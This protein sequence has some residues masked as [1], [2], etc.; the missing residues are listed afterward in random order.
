MN[1]ENLFLLQNLSTVV[2]TVGN[3][4]TLGLPMMVVYQVG[5]SLPRTPHESFPDTQI[6]IIPYHFYQ[7]Y[8]GMSFW[9]ISSE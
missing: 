9:I 4:P 6:K 3:T 1:T 2:P 5:L 7:S 8:T